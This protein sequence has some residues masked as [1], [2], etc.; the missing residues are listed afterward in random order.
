MSMN[1]T[2]E[3][4]CVMRMRTVPTRMV[5]TTASARKDTLGME[6]RAKVYRNSFSIQQSVPLSW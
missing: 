4:I 3:V 5:P 6:N 1:A 2:M